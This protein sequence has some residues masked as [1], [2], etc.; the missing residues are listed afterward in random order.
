V[1]ILREFAPFGPGNQRPVFLTRGLEISGKPRIVGKNHLKFRVRQLGTTFDAIGFGLGSFLS[2]IESNPSRTGLEC[3]FSLE[4]NDFA[5]R[6]GGTD[7]DTMPQLKVRDLRFQGTG[8]N[9]GS[10]PIHQPSTGRVGG[11]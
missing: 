9:V 11:S 2:E 7:G 10:L 3:V 8:T 4:E 5:P 6:S 1:R